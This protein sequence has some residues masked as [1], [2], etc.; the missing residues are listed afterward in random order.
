MVRWVNRI[1]RS[2]AG[3]AAEAYTLLHDFMTWARGSL[4]ELFLTVRCHVSGNMSACEPSARDDHLIIRVPAPRGGVEANAPDYFTQQVLSRVYTN[5]SIVADAACPRAFSR[6]MVTVIMG[7]LGF[8]ALV[9]LISSAALAL[10]APAEAM[11][12]LG[13]AISALLMASTITR[14]MLSLASSFSSSDLALLIASC[15][16]IFALLFWLRSEHTSPPARTTREV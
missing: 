16:P 15:V 9:T 4:H 10:V 11:A 14:T 6:G 13:T 3:I 8:A 1:P 12:M 2:C 5:T 7:T